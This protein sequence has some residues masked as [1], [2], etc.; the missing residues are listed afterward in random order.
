[1]IFII[2]ILS[3]RLSICLSVTRWYCGKTAKFIVEILSMPDSHI[4]LA[5]SEQQYHP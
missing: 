1:M 5:F 3:V 4:I 2:A